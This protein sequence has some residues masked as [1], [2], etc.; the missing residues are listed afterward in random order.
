MSTTA[1]GLGSKYFA[2]YEVAGVGIQWH[3]FS[4]S[5][6]E[7]DDFSLLLSMMMLIIDAVIY[8]VLTWYIE[9]VHPGMGLRGARRSHPFS[10]PP[11]GCSC[12]PGW[13][14]GLRW[15]LSRCWASG[16]VPMWVSSPG[17]YGLPRPWYFPL[18]KSYWLGN[19]RTE[20]WD[21]SWPWSQMTHL[22]V[23]EEDQACAME[24]RKMGK[25]WGGSRANVGHVPHCVRS[26]RS[27][28]LQKGRKIAL[29]CPP[30]PRSL[31]RSSWHAC[32]HRACCELARV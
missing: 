2:L 28:A 1:F 31:W 4:Q 21:W 23:T 19:G 18:Q 29:W 25:T 7:G 11:A 22:S 17:M 12:H 5:P 16:A 13:W 8:G 10:L 24:S 20:A 15:F 30:H 27:F 6:V 32:C 9:A 3:T 26:S 14:G